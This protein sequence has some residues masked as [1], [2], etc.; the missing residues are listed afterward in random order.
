MI[1]AAA[2]LSA[3]TI[4]NSMRRRIARLREP[5]YVIALAVGLLYFYWIFVRPGARAGTERFDGASMPPNLELLFA[6]ALLVFVALNWVFGS[7]R[8]PLPFTPAE[9]QFLFTAPLTRRQVIAFKLLRLQVP[10]LASALISVLL[11]SRGH[12]TPLRGLQIA[13]T[14]LVFT[15]V[16]LHF[17]GAAF[18]RANLAEHGVTGVRRQLVVLGLAGTVVGVAAWSVR[19]AWPE[20]AAAA[21]IGGAELFQAIGRISDD[22]ALAVILWPFRAAVGP[23]AARSAADFLAALPAAVLLL[24]LHYVWLIRSAMHFEEVAVEDAQR[25]ARRLEA[26]RRGRFELRSS[27]GKLRRPVYALRPSGPPAEAFLWKSLLAITRHVGPRVFVLMG[28]GI[29]AIVAISSR[30]DAPA[31]AGR[32]A[33]GTILMAVAALA[34]V[35]GP[36]ALRQDLREDLLLLDVL[37]SY[38]VRGREIVL[39]EVLGPTAALTLF[40]WVAGAAGFA[41]FAPAAAQSGRLDLWVVGLVAGVVVVPGIVLVQ[42]AVQNG[43]AVF[44][45]A[46]SALGTQVSAGVERLGQQILVMVGSILALGLSLIPAGLL[47]V[48]MFA[49]LRG[50][51]ETAAVVA[52]AVVVSGVLIFEAYLGIHFIGERL[53]QTDPAEVMGPE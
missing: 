51:N 35:F 48:V 41:L 32:M 27:G 18:V 19:W 3:R 11:F 50:I 17:A 22:G 21:R 29:L 14:W 24:A 38:P 28:A 4:V 46:W 6:W 8:N 36:R 45:P 1:A 40:A 20:L 2:Y 7:S 25:R 26:A 15:T 52:A 30:S 47:A 9:T 37:K 5:R 12:I 23:A 34:A 53:E 31:G 39:G 33:A 42:A 44:F 43:F 13:G 16:S 49:L 10:L